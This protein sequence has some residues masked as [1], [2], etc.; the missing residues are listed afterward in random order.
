[1]AT[2]L[3][4]AAVA[5]LRTSIDPACYQAI[6]DGF[7][8]EEP[9]LIDALPAL[10]K[11]RGLILWAAETGNPLTIYTLRHDLY[12]QFEDACEAVGL[13]YV[14]IP[15]QLADCPLGKHYEVTH[16]LPRHEDAEQWEAE[17][18]TAYNRYG[19]SI[20]THR[21]LGAKLP[22]QAD[23][24]C[25]FVTAHDEFHKALDNDYPGKSTHEP[26]VIIGNYRHAHTAFRDRFS[27]PE[28][29]PGLYTTGRYVAFDEFPGDDAIQEFDGDEIRKSV[30]AYLSTDSG[31]PF[32]SY[33]QLAASKN[34]PEYQD[35]I[36]DW[37]ERLTRYDQFDVGL[38]ENNPGVSP[39]A[40]VLTLAELGW[41]PP[42]SNGYL[43]A[44]IKG[45]HVA[46][47]NNDSTAFW[48]LRRPDL[49][50]AESVIA[51]DG[52]PTVL[53][54]EAL[55][56][57]IAQ[58][59]VLA[60]DTAKRSHLREGLGLRIIQTTDKIKPYAKAADFGANAHGESGEP[61]RATIRDLLAIQWI[62]HDGP[63][64]SQTGLI[65]TKRVLTAYKMAGLNDS[66]SQTQHYN[67]LIGTNEFEETRFGIV[68][69]CNY[70]GDE[71]VMMWAALRGHSV[72]PAEND[73]GKRIAGSNLSFG[74]LGDSILHGFRENDVLQ[75]VL[76]FGRKE[77]DG[78]KGATVYVHTSAI[79]EWVGP[80]KAYPRIHLW[81]DDY[82]GTQALNVLRN[83]QTRLP[84]SWT[85]SEFYE[86][87][88][89]EYG[90][91][92][93][94]EDSIKTRLD[95]FSELGLLESER[96]RGKGAGRGRP[97]QYREVGVNRLITY[98]TGYVLPPSH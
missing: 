17:L 63:V 55:I 92:A 46:V 32:T 95:E 4:S 58:L 68:G 86:L 44:E 22:C 8:Q 79:P 6:Q 19:S 21:I 41:S 83:K 87:V 39:L 13:Q 57:G 78:Q 33:N 70:P 64:D 11:S 10:G 18:E 12:R 45:D 77:V 94:H 82:A 56:P 76:R 34:L 1:M 61:T 3:D 14:R 24:E 74:P 93:K 97:K 16:G 38:S 72:K 69:G 91:K 98:S 67:N 75:A 90:D 53:L 37:K 73:D 80:E 35:D 36:E 26:D 60:D 54:W 42:M 49:H 7:E 48:L 65:T 23:G 51:L 62:L 9:A 66:I 89:T 5:S 52:T 40:P 43:R 29:G 20:A 81:E 25:P 84:D 50:L 59:E 15:S 88:L 2:E 30:D 96:P 71:V 27:Y 85:A 47:A 31:L 28:G